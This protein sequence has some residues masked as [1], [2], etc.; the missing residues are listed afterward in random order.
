[1]STN[2]EKLVQLMRQIDLL[3]RQIEVAGREDE[4][5]RLLDDVSKNPAVF[6]ELTDEEW[7]A[8]LNNEK[9]RALPRYY[10]SCRFRLR[11]LELQIS[12]HLEEGGLEKFLN[13]PYVRA[14]IKIAEIGTV[15]EFISH[16]AHAA[17]LFGKDHATGDFAGKADRDE[18]GHVW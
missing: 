6:E 16:I 13:M 10:C 4:C 3:G 12:R 5:L 1:M 15:L 9:E 14:V 11:Q 8:Y 17:G 18:D 7:D 2:Q